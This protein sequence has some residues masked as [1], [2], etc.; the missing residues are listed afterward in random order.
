MRREVKEAL[1]RVS[2]LDERDLAITM[3]GGYGTKR[4]IILS[5]DLRTI[6]EYAEASRGPF[7]DYF[8]PAPRPGWRR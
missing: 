5:M 8:P 1:D 3:G 6:I 2:P 4:R 7:G